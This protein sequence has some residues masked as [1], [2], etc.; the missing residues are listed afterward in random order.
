MK[1]LVIIPTYNEV[2]NLEKLVANIH[3]IVPQSDVLI[4]DDSSPD[5]TGKL[6]EQ[7]TKR[8]KKIK[9]ILRPHK[10]G[11]GSAYIQGFKYA[12]NNDYDYIFEMDA[13]LSHDPRYLADFL[14][15]APTH[16]LI[17]GSR[18]IEGGSISAWGTGR[19]TLSYLANIYARVLLGLPYRDLTG[20][21]KCYRREVL[22]N[23]G[24]DSII[25][26]GYVFQI[27]TTYRAHRKGY[28]IKEIPIVF[29]DRSRGKSKISRKICWE[30]IW[31][32]PLL[33]FRRT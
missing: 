8:N 5:G 25:S 15:Y 3:T 19:R 21:Y 30:A 27:E 11:L 2:G 4:I 32:V 17:L 31:K 12:L 16:Q 33:R 23:I 22:D 14:K 24:L 29:K 20:G 7:L 18:Y 1:T 13:D 26:E 10:A 9:L 28:T 6:A